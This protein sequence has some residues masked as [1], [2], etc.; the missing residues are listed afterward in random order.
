[1]WTSPEGAALVAALE[2]LR[3]RGT[4]SRDARIVLVFTGAGIKYDAPPLPPPV[5]LTGSDDAIVATVVRTL[6]AG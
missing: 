1:V 5:D 4:V 6:R 3:A 2:M